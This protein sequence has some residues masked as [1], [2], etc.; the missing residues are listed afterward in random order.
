MLN[1]LVTKEN[2]TIKSALESLLEDKEENILVTFRN[3]E[4][5]LLST[6][7]LFNHLDDEY[8]N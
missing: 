8:L 4:K 7:D 1:D 5:E 6:T 3:I 2:N